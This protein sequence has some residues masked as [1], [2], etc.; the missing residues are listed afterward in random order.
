[1]S[2]P[3]TVKIPGHGGKMIT[4]TPQNPQYELE[5]LLDAGY[6]IGA[7]V[8]LRGQVYSILHYDGSFTAARP[9]LVEFILLGPVRGNGHNEHFRIVDIENEMV[10]IPDMAAEGFLP[11]HEAAVAFG[12]DEKKVRRMLRQK[13]I[14]GVRYGKEWLVKVN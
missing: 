13:R 12:W 9:M 14:L 6:K 8:E 3:F 5:A 2:K 1:M 11:V 4:Y 7:K 10:L